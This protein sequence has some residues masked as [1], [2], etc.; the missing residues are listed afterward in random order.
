MTR[1]LLNPL[2]PHEFAESSWNRHDAAHLLRRARVGASRRDIDQALADGPAAAIERLLAVQEESPEFLA[3]DEALRKLAGN[4]GDLGDLQSWW[5]HRLLESANPLVEKMALFWHGHFA[6][7]N[8]KVQSLDEMAAQNDL[9]RRHA[10]GNFR[11][12][13]HDVSRDVAML[14]WLDGNANRRRQPNENFARE[15]MELFS[16]GVGNY[17]E[18]DIQ[19]AARA[20]SGWHVRNGEFWFN[21][22]QHDTSEKAVFG[23]TGNFDGDD[24]VELCLKQEAAPRFLATKLLRF[25]VTPSPSDH[26]IK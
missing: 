12:L 7:S 4:S 5:A 2:A 11:E 16:L 13:L 24:V 8:A 21:A 9:F 22:I 1:E 26:S 17:S 3:R 25:F 20:F 23:Q 15:L 6:T 14:N 19:E 18:K 10:L